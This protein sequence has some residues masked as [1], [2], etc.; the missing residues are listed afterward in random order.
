MLELWRSL[1]KAISDPVGGQ[2]YF[3]QAQGAFIPPM[4]GWFEG[5]V[6][7]QTSQRDLI[8]NVDNGAGDAALRFEHPLKPVDRGTFIQFRGVIDSYTKEPYRLGFLVEDQD[9][10]A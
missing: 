4:D 5:R 10:R 7:S 6:V 1:R 3:A 8:L 9:V 2:K